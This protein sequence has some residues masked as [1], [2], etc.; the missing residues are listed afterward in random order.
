M[1]TK[2]IIIC[3]I[4]I[5]MT[6]LLGWF[7][8]RGLR[9]CYD[10]ARAEKRDI[11]EREQMA[12]AD[13]LRRTYDKSKVA[14]LKY[15]VIAPV[16]IAILGTAVWGINR[17]VVAQK[18]EKELVKVEKIEESSDKGFFYYFSYDAN[19]ERYTEHRKEVYD[20]IL[21]S[22]QE[23]EEKIQKAKASG[24]KSEE[25]AQESLL[26]K[27][28]YNLNE[29]NAE[30]DNGLLSFDNGWKKKIRVSELG[31][32][33]LVLS[34][35]VVVLG[36]S[37]CKTLSILSSLIVN[38]ICGRVSIVIEG[39]PWVVLIFWIIMIVNLFLVCKNWKK[40]DWGWE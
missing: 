32:V 23:V 39:V 36:G 33:I 18:A 12:L 7:R 1:G 30:T 19:L 25:M 6:I 31:S 29:A 11:L 27:L 24:D 10:K 28:K 16:V 8:L 9:K 22:I 15:M 37:F 35:L 17:I 14:T 2:I 20:K 3:G 5:V 40:A 4:L 13:K 26:K 38:A 34:S 21:F